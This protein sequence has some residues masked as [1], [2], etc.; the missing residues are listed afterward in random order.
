MDH[1][2]GIA[3]QLRRVG[4]RYAQ[5][6]L[7]H[8]LDDHR[9]EFVSSASLTVEFLTKAVVATHDPASIFRRP[10]ELTDAERDVLSA[11]S[12]DGRR[13]TVEE[14]AAARRLLAAKRTIS[15]EDAVTQARKL[16]A[17]QQ[18]TL[19][20]AGAERLRHARNAVLHLGDTPIE[21]TDDLASIFVPLAE[22]LWVALRREANELWG[23][24]REAAA[25]VGKRWNYASW[26]ATRRIAQA[27][28][29]WSEL[30]PVAMNRRCR[31]VGREADATCPVC[32]CDAHLSSEPPGSAPEGLV[33]RDR[34]DRRVLVL[35]CL[36][37][38]LVLYGED[39]FR[40]AGRLPDGHEIGD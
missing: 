14:A 37:C 16:L 25:G 33:A 36:T 40:A 11:P 19:D 26:D 34:A 10:S 2:L 18:A 38:D 4:Q 23:H 8:H 21:P 29:R 28:K 3:E 22:E 32:G 17:G 5:A 1:G 31:L 24:L 12:R 13:P 9:F 27:R 6:A 35:D 39:Q 15:A 30:G 20:T 7:Q